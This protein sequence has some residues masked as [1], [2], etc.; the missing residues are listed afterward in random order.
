MRRSWIVLC[1]VLGL[2]LLPGCVY[3]NI[4]V[5]LDTD[6]NPTA[7][8]SR[9]GNASVQSVLGLVA[10]GDASTHAAAKD[11]NITTISHLDQEVFS[12]FGF[13]YAR[14]TTIAYGE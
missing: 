11:G 3:T 12:I 5:P 7:L 9:S 2:A 14:Q 1:A 13:L 8:G 10:W 6:M 4:R